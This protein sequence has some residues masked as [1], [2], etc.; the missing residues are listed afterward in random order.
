MREPAG[1]APSA[2]KPRSRPR[3]L[4]LLLLPC[5][6]LLLIGHALVEAAPYRQSSSGP[7]RSETRIHASVDRQ[8]APMYT[9]QS[10]DR[11]YSCNRNPHFLHRYYDLLGLNKQASKKDITKAYR[12]AAVKWHPDKNPD[13][14]VR[15]LVVDVDGVA[16]WVPFDNLFMDVWRCDSYL[17]I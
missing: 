9:I 10:T 17:S 5:L 11:L 7:N 16:K 6:L 1:A 2:S 3:E 13:A 8:S 14:K 12:R 4:L 15:G